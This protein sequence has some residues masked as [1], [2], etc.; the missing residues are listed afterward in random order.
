M[1]ASG[2][3]PNPTE[4]RS[5][6]RLICCWYL[7]VFVK[8][9]INCVLC[10]LVQ[11][12]AFGKSLIDHFMRCGWPKL[13]NLCGCCRWNWFARCSTDAESGKM[14]QPIDESQLRRHILA[15]WCKKRFAKRFRIYLWLCILWW[16]NWNIIGRL[17]E[18]RSAQNVLNGLSPLNA[19]FARACSPMKND[20]KHCCGTSSSQIN[21]DHGEIVDFCIARDPQLHSHRTDDDCGHGISSHSPYGTRLLIVRD[22][23]HLTGGRALSNPNPNASSIPIL[24]LPIFELSIRFNAKS[25]CGADTRINIGIY[26]WTA[27]KLEWRQNMHGKKSRAIDRIWIM[28]G[29]SH[30]G[31]AATYFDYDKT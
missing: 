22:L 31:A 1:A 3:S 8:L 12:I 4:N 9:A 28:A 17:Q 24:F 20:G 5:V 2:R 15:C 27:Q 21:D 18:V 29:R 16:I 14:K 6:H 10:P 11:M 23:M 25:N 13:M 7:F 30:S 26:I 19:K